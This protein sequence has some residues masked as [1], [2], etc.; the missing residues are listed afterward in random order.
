MSSQK[1]KNTNQ[2]T[3]CALLTLLQMDVHVSVVRI[4]VGQASTKNLVSQPHS[5]QT[6]DVRPPTVIRLLYR[7]RCVG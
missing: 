2:V 4:G 3:L 6:S 1:D 7:L 5:F